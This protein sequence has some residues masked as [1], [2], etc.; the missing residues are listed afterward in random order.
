MDR[1]ARIGRNDEADLKGLIYGSWGW[2]TDGESFTSH[3]IFH[4]E[5][6]CEFTD[7]ED[8]P[9]EGVPWCNWDINKDTK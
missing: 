9:A 7:H 5:G 8:K 1:R 4:K 6:L 2:S 3:L